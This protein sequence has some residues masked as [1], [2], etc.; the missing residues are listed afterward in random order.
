[1]KLDFS[2]PRRV[3]LV[4][5]GRIGL[6]ILRNYITE[7]NTTIYENPRIRLNVW[8]ALRMLLSGKRTEYAYYRA[9]LRWTKPHAVI[10]M[11]DNNITFYATKAISPTCKTIA[12]QN[13]VR[14]SHSHAADSDF[15]HDLQRL[16]KEGYDADIISTLGGLGSNFYRDALSD[17]RAH[18]IEVGH[19][20]NNALTLASTSDTNR[21]L[22]YI[23]KFPNRGAAG[24]DPEWDSKIIL[25]LGEVGLTAR[26]YYNIEAVAARACAVMAREYSLPFVVLGKRPEWQVG[27]RNFFAKHLAELPWEY[28]PSTYQAS[29]YESIRPDD[30]IVNVDST[31]G[32]ELFARGLRVVFVAA[33][34]H[35]AEHPEIVEHRFGYPLITDASG[36]YWTS[37]SS[38]SE[39][40]RVL[41]TAIS[42][43][44]EEWST[45]TR[46]NR[47]MLFHFDQGNALF[48]REL[49]RIGI[50]NTG[51]RLWTRELIPR[52]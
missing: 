40:R 38:D 50:S 32:Y 6:G 48:C 7:T 16:N 5:F 12:V 17:S 14:N 11:E 35:A 25:Y 20:M 31:L 18:L 10:T 37:E 44:N 36:P 8:V 9:F 23:S 27:E 1:M 30:I 34:M 13:G 51:P 15:K 49:D 43:S 2:I 52:N 45:L 33:R 28:M 3:R 24:V 42:V 4:Y 41:Q 29:S 19:L 22:V 26:Q 46:N 47:Q 21:R 39:I